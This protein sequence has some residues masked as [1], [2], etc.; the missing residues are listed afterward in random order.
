ME[1]ENRNGVI[2]KMI[3][4]NL[5]LI[6]VGVVLVGVV[7]FLGYTF[8]QNTAASIETVTEVSSELLTA[9]IQEISE[10][11]TLSYNYRNVIVFQEQT[12]IGLFGAQLGI[13]GTARSLIVAYSGQM[14]LGIDTSLLSVNVN[15]NIIAIS[16]PPAEILIHS[17]D[18]DSIAVLNEDS[19]LFASAVGIQ[20]FADMVA[21]EQG[22]M[23]QEVLSSN[24][25]NEARTNAEAAIR[26]LLEVIPEVTENYTIVF[27]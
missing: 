2:S 15:N 3:K 18:M 20:E 10:L 1:N 25:L 12:T 14:R 9:S 13:P 27:N 26:G 4:K 8:I 17:I 5:A 21:A 22:S 16:L 7:G 23:E 6:I 19:G 11:S 24:M